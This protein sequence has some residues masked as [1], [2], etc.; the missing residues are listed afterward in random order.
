M[1][2]GVSSPDAPDEVDASIVKT[3][4]SLRSR[5]TLS[6][7]NKKTSKLLTNNSC[8]ILKCDRKEK[9][10]FYDKETASEKRRYL[11]FS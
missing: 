7:L 9:H 8:Y 6:I 3:S 1:G 10:Y 4:R 11:T 5:T 2:I